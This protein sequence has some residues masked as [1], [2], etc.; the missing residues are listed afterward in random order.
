MMSGGDDLYTINKEEIISYLN[1]KLK[2]PNSITNADAI[3]LTKYNNFKK[4]DKNTTF[5]NSVNAIKFFGQVIIDR[6][7][8]NLLDEFSIYIIKDSSGE[9][10]KFY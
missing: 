6:L 3:I 10:I 5:E 1:T 9:V 7:T 4:G 8:L 2:I